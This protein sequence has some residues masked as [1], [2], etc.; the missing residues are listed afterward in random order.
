MINGRQPWRMKFA[1]M[2]CLLKVIV[3]ESP[4]YFEIPP[5]CHI[6]VDSLIKRGLM[7]DQH[8]RPFAGTLRDEAD[9]ALAQISGLQFIFG[10]Q[11]AE[12]TS[13]PCNENMSETPQYSFSTTS[14]LNLL[15]VL[16]G[17]AD[18]SPGSDLPPECEDKVNQVQT[19]QIM[20]ETSCEKGQSPQEK[21]KNATEKDKP[22]GTNIENQASTL[23]MNQQL[24]HRKVKCF[25]T[26]PTQLQQKQRNEDPNQLLKDFYRGILPHN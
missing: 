9:E 16:E 3:E 24:C 13:P 23:K 7:V 4:P 21:I 25:H 12:V 1:E 17:L 26:C 20:E 15:S 22:C 6:L 11:Y 14:T 5:S 18:P 10:E 2:Q 19:P 8:K